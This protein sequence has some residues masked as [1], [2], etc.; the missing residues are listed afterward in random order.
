[1]YIIH[2]ADR[3]VFTEE[4]RTG[5]YGAKSIERY[6]FVHC[7]DLDTYYLVAPN[8][9]DERNEKVILVIDTDKLS[10]EVKW[11]DGGGLDF[12]H[13]YGLVNQEAIADILDHLWSDEREWV[14]NE[15]LKQY[16]VDGFRRE[17]KEP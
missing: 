2:V 12:P 4:I 8:F 6:G 15:E 5:F 7:S 9:R 3:D 16:A 14:P 1:M 11:E 10:S 17:W 13:V